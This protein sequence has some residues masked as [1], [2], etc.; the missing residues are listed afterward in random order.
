ME[1]SVKERTTPSQRT[2]LEARIAGSDRLVATSEEPDLD[3]ALA[4]VR[5]ELV[6]Q[7]AD[8][9]NRTEPRNR[10]SLRKTT[11]TTSD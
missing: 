4:E 3:K 1:V 11:E 9:K 10:R 6:R 2:E 8:A 5:D 7:L